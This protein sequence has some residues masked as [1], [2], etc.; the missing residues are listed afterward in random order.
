VRLLT[1]PSGGRAWW[2]HFEFTRV[3][4]A[5]TILE[6]K[7]EERPD[8][9]AS[10]RF[11]A[12]IEERADRQTTAAVSGGRNDTQEISRRLIAGGRSRGRAEVL[13]SRVR[14]LST[15]SNQAHS[16]A[17]WLG[18][19]KS[20]ERCAAAHSTSIDAERRKPSG[21]WTRCDLDC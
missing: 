8:M 16:G 21:A 12:R 14:N 5:L 20:S 1:Q 10:M 18:I 15:E 2:A 9:Q 6:K 17:L 4:I 13:L 7:M 11:L 19:V 3:N